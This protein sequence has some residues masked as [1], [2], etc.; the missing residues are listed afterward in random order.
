MLHLSSATEWSFLDLILLYEEQE[1]KVSNTLKKEEFP[2]FGHRK[3]PAATQ[4]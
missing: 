4:W 3:R 2:V 1:R